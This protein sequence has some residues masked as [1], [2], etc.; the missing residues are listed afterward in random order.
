MTRKKSKKPP[1]IRRK[2]IFPK[3]SLRPLVS[4]SISIKGATF[5]ALVSDGATV[6]EIIEKVAKKHD[7]GVAKVYNEE[8]GE[9]EIVVV[10]IGEH[11]L[12]S[13]DPEKVSEADF[14]NFKNP[15]LIKAAAV[16]ASVEASRESKGGIHLLEIKG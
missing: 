11:L 1:A 2:G 9:H 4:R 15:D 12:A 10:K 8:L 13:G 7:G 16:E 14:S 6:E 3:K 5:S